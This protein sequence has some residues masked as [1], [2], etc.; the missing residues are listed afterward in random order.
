MELLETQ[1]PDKKRLI[2][3]SNRHRQELERE[4]SDIGD[5]TQQM[6][7]NA[8][9]IGGAL[10]LTYVVVNQLTHRKS[11]K[12]KSKNAA[13]KETPQQETIQAFEQEDSGPSV[14]SEIG[15][16]VAGAATVFLLDLAKEKIADYLKSNKNK[17]ENS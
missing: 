13:A 1:D 12:K 6:L 4:V 14:L 8:L 15:N 10:A 2:E 9:I 5:R 16:K 7:K 17:D 3:T 11:K